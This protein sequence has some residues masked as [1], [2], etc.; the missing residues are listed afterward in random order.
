MVQ[1]R[2]ITS[3]LR[4]RAAERGTLL[5]SVDKFLAEVEFTI[6]VKQAAEHYFRL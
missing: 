5:A 3:L 4:R 6:A 1:G 2:R